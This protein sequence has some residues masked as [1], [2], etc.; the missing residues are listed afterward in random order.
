MLPLGYH[1]HT[2]VPY[3]PIDHC[4]YVLHVSKQQETRKM[5]ISSGKKRGNC[6]EQI[7]KNRYVRGKMDKVEEERNWWI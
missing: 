7:M 2:P 5:D 6:A 1:T 3:R 4:Y